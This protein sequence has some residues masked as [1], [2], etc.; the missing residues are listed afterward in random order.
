MN[1]LPISHTAIWTPTKPVTDISQFA[2]SISQMTDLLKKLGAAV[3]AANQVGVDARIFVSKYSDWPVVINPNW[4]PLSS[5]KISKP[6]GSVSKPGYNPFIPRFEKITAMF[7][8][9]AGQPVEMTLIGMDARVY[10]HAFDA[11]DGKMIF[12]R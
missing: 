10:Q 12:T 7:T 1:L 3:I 9:L 5:G 11:L 8:N 2:H 6:E 4:K